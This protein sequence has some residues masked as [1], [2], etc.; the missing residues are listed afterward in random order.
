VVLTNLGSAKP[1]KIAHEVAAIY[2]SKSGAP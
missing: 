2:L 1:D